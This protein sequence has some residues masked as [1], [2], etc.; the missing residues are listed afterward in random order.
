VCRGF[1]R[2]TRIVPPRKE[3]GVPHCV[4]ACAGVET[5]AAMRGPEGVLIRVA[6]AKTGENWSLGD[7]R[8]VVEV[9]SVRPLL[10]RP[11]APPLL[12]RRRERM[13]HVSLVNSSRTASGPILRSA[14][15]ETP[16]RS[17][18]DGA[19]KCD[20]IH[21]TAPLLKLIM[22]SGTATPSSFFP[23]RPPCRICPF[24]DLLTMP[25]CFR[26]TQATLCRTHTFRS[27]TPARY[28]LGLHLGIDMYLR[29]KPCFAV[30]KR[31]T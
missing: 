11:S 30:N 27:S 25:F 1:A 23:K 29:P 12:H 16:K 6:S 15:G 21:V 22:M 26:P 20:T 5:R 28:H 13:H 19:R 2:T 14:G 3:T 18:S 7:S 8:R 4:T 17:S 10:R 9:M 24:R 31:W